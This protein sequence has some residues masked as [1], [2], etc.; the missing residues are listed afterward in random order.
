VSVH[1]KTILLVD[2]DSRARAELRGRLEKIGISVFEAG[3]GASALHIVARSQVGLVITE[4][5]V[6]C[7]E[8]TC[9]V[10]AMRRTQE[11]SRTKVLAYTTHTDAVDRDW[12]VRAGADAY[13]VKPTLPERLLQTAS[14][15]LSSRAPSRRAS[16]NAR[17]P[18]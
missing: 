18:H 1:Q 11:L 7:G 6:P 5:Y 14:S 15:L 10:R 13:L 3:D 17:A 4:L 12:A 2:P 9:F 8:A 16:G